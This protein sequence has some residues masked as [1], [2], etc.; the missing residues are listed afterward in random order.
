MRRNSCAEQIIF[1]DAQVNHRSPL[2]HYHYLSL[3]KIR[4]TSPVG[5]LSME[6]DAAMH[7]IVLLYPLHCI[8][9]PYS[10][11]DDTLRART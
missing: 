3:F 8:D 2:M 9:P 6:V 7:C 10:Y 4:V 11:I 1:E 5:V